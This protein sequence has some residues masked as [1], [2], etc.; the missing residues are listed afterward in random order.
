MKSTKCALNSEGVSY[1]CF[2]NPIY[3]E[4]PFRDYLNWILWSSEGWFHKSKNFN[5]REN[6]MCNKMCNGGKV[7][8]FSE[9][10]NS[11]V[12]R[13]NK[14]SLSEQMFGL[15]SQ[16]YPYGLQKSKGILGILGFLFYLV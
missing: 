11:F 6:H 8:G 12:F 15:Q 2:G 16:N 1:L 9:N 5:L 13:T 4:L 10:A 7:L 14:R 3:K